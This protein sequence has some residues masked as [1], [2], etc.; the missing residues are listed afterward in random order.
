MS[1]KELAKELHKPFIRKFQKRKVHSSFIGNICLADLP[2]M[3]LISKLDKGFRFLL[4]VIGIYSKYA[5]VIPLKGKKGTTI[6]NAFQKM[7]N[8]SNRKPNEIW[9]DKGSEIYSRSTKSL[10]GKTIQKCIQHI[11]KE[12]LFLLKDLLET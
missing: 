7:L 11:T 2:D 8:E 5:W 9:V 3:Q 12:N 10:L 1:N 6:T 4:F